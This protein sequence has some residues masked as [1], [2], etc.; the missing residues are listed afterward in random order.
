MQIWGHLCTLKWNGRRYVN[1]ASYRA[2]NYH[3]SARGKSG[4][5]QHF[6]FRVSNLLVFLMSK[7][8]KGKNIIQTGEN[9]KE[10]PAAG[11]LKEGFILLPWF[12]P[13]ISSAHLKRSIALDSY[14]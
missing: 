11:T 6:Y 12:E 7:D 9:S 1:E 3:W 4:T 8:K 14:G 10:I 2:L 5:L 13:L